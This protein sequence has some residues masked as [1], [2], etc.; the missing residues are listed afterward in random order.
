MSRVAHGCKQ[1]HRRAEPGRAHAWRGFCFFFIIIYSLL[2]FFFFQI[3]QCVLQGGACVRV[4]VCFVLA[5]GLM[6]AAAVALRAA[7]TEQR[8]R[9]IKKETSEMFTSTA[10]E[11]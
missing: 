4:C 1:A 6:V 3:S 9:G 7:A 2:D 11:E 5:V 10:E 8:T